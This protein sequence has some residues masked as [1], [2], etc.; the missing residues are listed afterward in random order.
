MILDEEEIPLI[1]TQSF[2]KISHVKGYHVYQA[3]WTPVIREYLLS[4]LKQDNLEDKYVS[5]KKKKI[6]SLDICH[7]EYLANLLKQFFIS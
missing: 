6:K 3:F 1:L 7:W 4:E 2:E 5:V